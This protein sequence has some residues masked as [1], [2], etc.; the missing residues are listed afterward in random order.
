MAKSILV[1]LF[2]Y[3]QRFY[4]RFG[5]RDLLDSDS[6]QGPPLSQQPTELREIGG[7]TSDEMKNETEWHS[8][9]LKQKIAKVCVCVHAHGCVCIHVCVCVV[10]A[11]VCVCVFFHIFI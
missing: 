4:E 3:Q 1:C 8:W 10:C 11:C 5:K 6:K 7:M 2:F 9:R